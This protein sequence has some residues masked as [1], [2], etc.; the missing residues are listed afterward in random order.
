MDIQL[1][2]DPVT[3][4]AEPSSIGSLANIYVE[5]GK[6]VFHDIGADRRT[7]LADGEVV[8]FR[9][10]EISLRTQPAWRQGKAESP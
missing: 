6:V 9:E 8:R 7:E 2:P 4:S 5:A 1:R 10:A 3:K